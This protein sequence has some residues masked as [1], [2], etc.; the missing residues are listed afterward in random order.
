MLARREKE[1]LN[2]GSAV[3]R[4][5]RLGEHTLTS[6]P[7]RFE[8]GTIHQLN[9]AAIAEKITT[10]L[11]VSLSKESLINSNFF[12]STEEKNLCDIE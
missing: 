7:Q 2:Q 5:N 6:K 12:I 9:S 4:Y 3:T 11:A 1:Y 8:C 10:L